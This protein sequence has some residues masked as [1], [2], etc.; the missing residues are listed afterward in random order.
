[1]LS[2]LIQTKTSKVDEHAELANDCCGNVGIPK[3]PWTLTSDVTIGH[4][5]A[6][7]SPLPHQAADARR[8][9]DLI[10]SSLLL[11]AHFPV[12]QEYRKEGKERDSQ[13]YN[14]S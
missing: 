9:I 6:V 11:S 5:S 13:V 14:F 12:Q 8:W 3:T 4:L 10:K 1:M 2:S 7:R